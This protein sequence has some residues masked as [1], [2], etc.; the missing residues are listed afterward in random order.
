[1]DVVTKLLDEKRKEEDAGKIAPCAG[2][3]S[4]KWLLDETQKAGGKLS[5]GVQANIVAIQKMVEDE[6]KSRFSKKR[7][8]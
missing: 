7:I 6:G 2:H 5:A 1:M 3:R 8:C 4:K